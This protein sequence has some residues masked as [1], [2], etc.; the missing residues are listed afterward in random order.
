MVSVVGDG[1]TT[2]GAAL[3]RLLDALGAGAMRRLVAGPL[4]MSALVPTDKL[5]EAQRALHAAFVT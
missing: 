1:L 2:S 4:R 5:G 3:S